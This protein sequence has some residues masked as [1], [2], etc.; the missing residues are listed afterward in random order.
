MDRAFYL[1]Y[2]F[3]NKLKITPIGIACKLGSLQSLKVLVELGAN[4]TKKIG[5]DKL[6]PLC[7]VAMYDHFECAECLCD[8]KGRVN[9]KDKFDRTPLILAARNGH[10]RMASLLL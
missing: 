6:T 5:W 7:Y 4:Q 3:T 9:G 2:K 8:N 10:T 1:E